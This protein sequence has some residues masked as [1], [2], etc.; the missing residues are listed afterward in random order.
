[1]RSRL[2]INAQPF[3][4]QYPAFAND[5]DSGY[6][7]PDGDSL[8]TTETFSVMM[9]DTVS[10][11]IDAA[12]SFSTLSS[13]TWEIF[14]EQDDYTVPEISVFQYGFSSFQPDVGSS[15][16]WCV[17]E[18]MGLDVSQIPLFFPTSEEWTNFETTE[19]ILHEP[20]PIKDWGDII[21]TL[22]KRALVLF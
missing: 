4:P 21:S 1:M 19:C 16:Q 11:F 10:A 8:N 6:G 15:E 7:V 20:Q 9:D 18:P 2:K 22:E 3:I 12:D 13:V 5:Q 14:N 17:V